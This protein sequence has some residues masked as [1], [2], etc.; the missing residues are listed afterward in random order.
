MRIAG[1][2]NWWMPERAK[3]ILLVRNQPA[4]EESS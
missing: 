1:E 4:L 2:W 3:K